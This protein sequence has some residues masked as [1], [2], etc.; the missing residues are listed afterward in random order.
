MTLTRFQLKIL[1]ICSMFLDHAMKIFEDVLEPA[2]GQTL[3]TAVLSLGRMAFL[4]FAFQLAEGV[5]HTHNVK[6]YLKRLFGFAQCDDDP[7][8]GGV[9]LR[10]LC[11]FRA[12]GQ[13]GYGKICRVCHCAAGGDYGD[14]LR[15]LWRGFCF[16]TLVY[17]A[18][19]SA[20]ACHVLDDTF[21]LRPLDS[22]GAFV[23]GD[24]VRGCF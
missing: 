6:A 24:Y 19:T 20:V 7:V 16:C 21:L 9:V 4:I 12:E 8:F 14:G 22:S 15:R 3:Y 11:L 1:A 5:W 13:K 17:M 18:F 23:L 10:C 2:M